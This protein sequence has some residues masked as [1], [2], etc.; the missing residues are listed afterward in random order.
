MLAPHTVVVMY[1]YLFHNPSL[2]SVVPDTDKSTEAV[3]GRG[4]VG[5]IHWQK[6]GKRGPD[7]SKDGWS[8]ILL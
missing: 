4:K 6:T 5:P 2:L 8:I 3:A 7:T 1:N